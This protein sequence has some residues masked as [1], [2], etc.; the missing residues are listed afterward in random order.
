M[1]IK[2]ETAENLKEC[3]FCGAPAQLIKGQ[4]YNSDVYRVE[5]PRCCASAARAHIGTYLWYYG[6]QNVTFTDEQARQ[7]AINNWNCRSIPMEVIA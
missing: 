4:I 2:I 3:P 5:C 6:K 1:S 7:Q